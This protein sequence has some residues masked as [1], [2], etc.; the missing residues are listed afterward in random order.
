MHHNGNGVPGDGLGA[1]TADPYDALADLFLG[2]V[3]NGAASRTP[4]QPE[5]ERPAPRLTDEPR[6][7]KPLIEC[8]VLGHLP[9][10]GA[11]WA[12]QYARTLA[13]ST[14]A[15]V[16]VATLRG[17]HLTIE[18]VGAR[19]ADARLSTDPS[20][21]AERAAA[22]TERWVVRTDEPAGTLAASPEV[23]AVTLLTAGDQASIVG[24][25]AAIK[26]LL[27]D[28]ASEGKTIRLAIMGTAPE[29]AENAYARLAEAVRSF[30]GRRVER[31]PGS[32]RIA[33]SGPSAVLFSG[34]ASF[35]AAA[36]VALIAKASRQ[37]R[38]AAH[39]PARMRTEEPTP[40][41][42]AP[43]AKS[44]AAGEEPSLAS[45]VP[46]LCPVEVRCPYAPEVELAR[47]DE[48]DSAGL[49]LLVRSGPGA[50]EALAA[51]AAWARAHAG[52]LR[53]AGV[54]AQTDAEPVQHIFVDDARPAMRLLGTP[55]R[56]HLLAA[57]SE[58]APGGWLCRP[59]N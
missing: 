25:Y 34:P 58:A 32:Q 40:A 2:D 48:P 46:G 44:E 36:L 35:D 57:A 29:A 12:S 38:P 47:G 50:L 4:A 39:A 1:G 42:P 14:G 59:L 52:L 20:E 33:A 21:A 27:D 10:L 17:G 28:P 18:V 30:A 49:H 23:G 22:M 41:A 53:S 24:S 56:V 37:P 13:E 51:A 7:G 8:V 3:P 31:A 26:R 5:P 19:A 9:V 16:G 55:V 54:P 43:V 15:A 6:Q 45:L 11:P